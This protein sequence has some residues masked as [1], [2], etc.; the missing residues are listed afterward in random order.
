M[1]EVIGANIGYIY[2]IIDRNVVG[3]LASSFAIF[4]YYS[5]DLYLNKIIDII[6]KKKNI[7]NQFNK[8][9][10]SYFAELVSIQD[11]NFL[12]GFSYLLPF[13]YHI[14]KIEYKQ[15]DI[16]KL[17]QLY[18]DINLQKMVKKGDNYEEIN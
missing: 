8:E 9:G 15:V 12:H 11:K 3:V 13:P 2:N 6:I 17:Y 16:N 14:D 1:D 10:N 4:A 7:V 5:N 18:S